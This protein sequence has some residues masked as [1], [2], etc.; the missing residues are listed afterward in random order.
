MTMIQYIPN[1]VIDTDGISDG[2]SIY[3]YESGGTTLVNLYSDEDYSTPVSNPY[4]V[5]GGAGVPVLH[6]NHDGDVRLRVV[7]TSG[8]VPMDIDPYNPFVTL[9]ELNDGDGSEIG[10]GNGYNLQYILETADR[11]IY[12]AT[13]GSDSTG[14]GT[15]VNPYATPQKCVD[16]LPRIIIKTFRIVGSAGTYSTSSRSAVSMERPSVVYIDQVTILKRTFQ[17]GSDL[18]GGLVFDFS[19][20]VIIQPN[21]TYPRG[22]YATANC[23]SVG[24]LGGTF[25]AAAGAESLIVT[26]RGAYIHGRDVTLDGNGIASFGIL[27]ES[28]GNAEMVDCSATG[29]TVA[30]VITDTGGGF[31]QFA[32]PANTSTIGKINNSSI[33]SLGDNVV[34]T[35]TI[36]HFGNRFESKVSAAS[37]AVDLQGN[38]FGWGG[39]FIGSW[40]NFSNS[41]A[42]VE[43]HNTTIRGDIWRFTAKLHLFD[44]EVQGNGWDS[45]LVEL[46]YDAEVT[47]F[48]LGEVVTGGTS[49][50]TGTV[51]KRTDVGGGV[52]SLMLTAVTGTFS[53]NEALTGSVAGA[54][55]ANGATAAPNSTHAEPMLL[56]G[57][58]QFS[59]RYNT[60]TSQWGTNTIRN[61]AGI[62]TGPQ[63]YGSVQTFSA[64]AGT[65]ALNWNGGHHTITRV[66]NSTGGALTNMVLAG[67]LS[68]G[69]RGG[70]NQPP[71]GSLWTFYT[72]SA[73]SLVII[74]ST[75]IVT[76]PAGSL[77]L[78][79][80]AAAHRSLTFMWSRILGAFMLVGTNLNV[81]TAPLNTYVAPVG[82]ATIDAECRASL[83]QLA[84]DVAN[85]KTKTQAAKIHL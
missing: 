38:F 66:E 33:V 58:S 65:I 2:A 52:G 29:A 53:D 3:V 64:S 27:S 82:G 49:G 51:W 69:S 63:Y 76:L 79:T 8:D 77:I 19:D 71:D 81:Q 41:A 12:F 18:G 55:T 4:I 59:G 61:S 54:A 75:T 14:D 20:N 56:Y 36:N 11:S 32:S 15:I 5:A 57:S 70:G 26:H 16:S 67:T 31:I 35:G 25:L 80:A 30:D 34:V 10:I 43:F 50:A 62:L 47:A 17:S 68:T 40:I 22:F 78:G 24:I 13:T 74:P 48:A 84:A 37:K 1:R 9:T 42:R 46:D 72:T 28:G 83:A 39:S 21:A 60:A 73:Q 23:G 6:T 7:A 85:L 45:Y 44:T